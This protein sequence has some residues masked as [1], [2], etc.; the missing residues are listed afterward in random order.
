MAALWERIS[1]IA[2]EQYGVVSLAQLLAAGFTRRMVDVAVSN[3]RLLPLH[4]G[5]FAVGHMARDSRAGRLAATLAIPAGAWVSNRSCAE[6]HHVLRA[7]TGPVHV[8]VPA[9]GGRKPRKGIVVHRAMLAEDERT[10][11][12][13]VPCTTMSRTLL[14]LSAERPGELETAIKA[15]GDRELLRVSECLMLMKRYPGRPGSPLLR[16]MLV[17]EEPLPEFTRSGLERRMYRLCRDAGL[18]LPSMTVDIQGES[19]L[20]ECDCA[21]SRHRLIIECD[22]R[23][24]DNPITSVADAKKS[25][26]LTLAGWRVERLRWAQIVLEPELCARTVAHLLAEQERLMAIA[27]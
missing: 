4:R 2:S 20:H 1:A 11:F 13:G 14:D 3:G 12:E 18:P 19:D 27:A 26:D 22:S 21:W 9:S 24:H 5:V 16:R 17:G 8:T 15:A 7:R 25:Q 6:H 10:I 23:W